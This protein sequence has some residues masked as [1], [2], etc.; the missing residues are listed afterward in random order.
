MTLNKLSL[1]LSV[2]DLR[3]W[4]VTGIERCKNSGMAGDNLKDISDPDVK[5]EKDMLVFSIKKKM[6]FVPISL[7]A[8]VGIRATDDGEGVA[9]RLGG[10]SAAFFSPA[11]ATKMV[12]DQVAQAVQGRPGFSVADDTLTIT[13]QAL[14]GLPNFS[15]TGAIHAVNV[16]NDALVVDIG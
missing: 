13:K 10:I 11:S 16:V 7:S 5:V 8:K 2:S 15:I 9:L 4:L 6:G 12:M 14:A 3:N 1:N